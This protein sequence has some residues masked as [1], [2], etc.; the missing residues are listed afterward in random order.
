MLLIPFRT[1]GKPTHQGNLV[2]RIFHSSVAKA[3]LVALNLIPD[4]KWG[5]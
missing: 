3:E 2:E 4:T 5:S 1:N